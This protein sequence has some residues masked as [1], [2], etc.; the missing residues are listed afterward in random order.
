MEDETI[1][2]TFEYNGKEIGCI[3][4]GMNSM[5]NP[6][7]NN[8][9]K[10][11]CRAFRTDLTGFEAIDLFNEMPPKDKIHIQHDAYGVFRL[12]M[13]HQINPDDYIENEDIMIHITNIGYKNLTEIYHNDH[14]AWELVKQRGLEGELFQDFKTQKGKEF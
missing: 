7:T 10:K 1:I 2:R 5:V 14:R 12:L 3:V 13:H 6:K 11:R 9:N 4:E 8:L